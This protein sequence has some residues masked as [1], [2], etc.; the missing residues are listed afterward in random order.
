MGLEP[1]SP[2]LDSR[3]MLI[4]TCSL[5]LWRRCATSNHTFLRVVRICIGLRKVILK[6]RSLQQGRIKSPWYCKATFT[7]K[8]RRKAYL[9]THIMRIH[10]QRGISGPPASTS[11]FYPVS[12]R[13]VMLWHLEEATENS[14]VRDVRDQRHGHTTGLRGI[15]GFCAGK[16]VEYFA[17]SLVRLRLHEIDIKTH[18]GD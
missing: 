3:N 16:A 8:G 13:S 2:T 7:A 5:R 17:R 14:L 10:T 15:R 11:S 1:P 12:L 18:P 9:H 4:R 6:I